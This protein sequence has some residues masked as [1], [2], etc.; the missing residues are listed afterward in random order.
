MARQRRPSTEHRWRNLRTGLHRAGPRRRVGSRLPRSRTMLTAE[1]TDAAGLPAPRTLEEAGLGR[2]LVSQLV[3]KTLHFSGELTGTELARRIG[4]PFTAIEP[5]LT[6]I[7]Q[8]H[9]CEVSGG[10]LGS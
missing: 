1:T 8:Q 4:L 3:L 5:L 6:G 9:Q 7:K 2:D 10:S